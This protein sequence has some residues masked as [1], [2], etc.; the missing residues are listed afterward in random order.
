MTSYLARLFIVSLVALGGVFPQAHAA[1]RAQIDADVDA[2]L[3]RFD[4]EIGGARDLVA[5]AA[6][7]WGNSKGAASKRR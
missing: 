1:P 5:Q 6:W 3:Y 2:A 4:R 7:A